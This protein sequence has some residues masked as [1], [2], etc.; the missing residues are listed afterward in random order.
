MRALA[1]WKATYSK[2]VGFRAKAQSGFTPVQRADWAILLWQDHVF[3]Y[4]K[5]RTM[6]LPIAN[7]WLTFSLLPSL[8]F[9]LGF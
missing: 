8:C 2:P 9:L 5:G 7:L 1:A 3:T 6:P 4:S